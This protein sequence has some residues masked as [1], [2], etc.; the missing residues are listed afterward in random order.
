M[1]TAIK[2][3]KTYGDMESMQPNLEDI[4]KPWNLNMLKQLHPG[5]FQLDEPIKIFKT[6]WVRFSVTCIQ[7]GPD[8]YF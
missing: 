5:T 1:N 3:K 8:N 4:F 2:K 7:K 6:F